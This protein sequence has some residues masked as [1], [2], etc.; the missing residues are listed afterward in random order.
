[1]QVAESTFMAAFCFMDPIECHAIAR[2][3]IRTAGI[4]I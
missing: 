3:G 1:M 4:P 2:L